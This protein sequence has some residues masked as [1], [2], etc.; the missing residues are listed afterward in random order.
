MRGRIVRLALLGGLLVG[1]TGCAVLLIGAGAAGGYAV[2][3]DSVKN[4]LDVPA[5]QVYSTSR[6]VLGELGFVTEEDESKGLLQA[7]VR[8]VNVTVRI[9]PVSEKLVEFK[10]KARNKLFIPKLDT[11]MAV[12]NHVMDR[13]R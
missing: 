5:G 10:V 7:T 4:E 13:L 12:Y 1:L 6:A 2:S 3:R 8:G 11:A 9:R